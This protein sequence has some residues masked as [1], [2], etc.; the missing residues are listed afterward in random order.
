M[1]LDPFP[2][3]QAK[4]PE[5]T[6]ASCRHWSPIRWSADPSD[7]SRAGK[8]ASLPGLGDCYGFGLP[9]GESRSYESCD[10]Y[11]PRPIQGPCLHP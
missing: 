4:P 8:L 10:A 9:A 7:P 6:C 1:S 3:P 5:R 2:R 11:R